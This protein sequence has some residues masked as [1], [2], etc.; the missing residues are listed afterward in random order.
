MACL[1]SSTMPALRG[2]RPIRPGEKI[3]RRKT[4]PLTINPVTG[5]CT[6][7]RANRVAP[8]PAS[9]S[10]MPRALITRQAADACNNKAL[11][12]ARLPSRKDTTPGT[13][14]GGLGMAGGGRDCGSGAVAGTG[15]SDGTA[16]ASWVEVSA[17][18]AACSIEVR[19]H[20]GTVPS[21]ATGGGA[22]GGRTTA[23]AGVPGVPEAA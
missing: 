12:N 20:P 5:K 10:R 4:A 11:H 22:A 2:G 8:S 7:V 1:P 17:V 16:A 3:A 13:F 6:P 15:A 18:A 23:G 19:D 14:R 9:A 21:P